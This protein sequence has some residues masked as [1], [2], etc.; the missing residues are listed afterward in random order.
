MNVQVNT[1]KYTIEINLSDDS[2]ASVQYSLN[3]SIISNTISIPAIADVQVTSLTPVN[4]LIDID[5]TTKVSAISWYS[6]TEINWMEYSLSSK[7]MVIKNPSINS[8][9]LGLCK[10]LHLRSVKFWSMKYQPSCSNIL[11]SA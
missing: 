5:G 4:I 10:D 8:S 11:S 6:N 1:S 7:Y 9:S 2:G 3:I